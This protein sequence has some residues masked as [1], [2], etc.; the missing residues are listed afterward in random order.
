MDPR[1]EVRLLVAEALNRVA[2]DIAAKASTTSVLVGVAR[3]PDDQVAHRAVEALGKPGTD[4]ALAVPA[5]LECLESTNALI[6]CHAVWA[7]E[8]GTK[9]FGAFSDI[10]TPALAL[11]AQRKDNVGGYARIA[12]RRWKTPPTSS[13]SIQ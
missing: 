6:A 9:Q 7:L 5:L 1:S 2:P 12:L 8:R 4:P 3:H 13:G 10:V 11:A